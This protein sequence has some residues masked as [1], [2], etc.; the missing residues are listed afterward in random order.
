MFIMLATKFYSFW[1]YL[2]LFL[3]KREGKIKEWDDT[4]RRNIHL[5]GIEYDND[6]FHVTKAKANNF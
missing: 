6:N 5:G 2:V 4:L 1:K 3:F